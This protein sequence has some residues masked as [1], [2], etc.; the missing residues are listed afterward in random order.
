MKENNDA[1]FISSFCKDNLALPKEFDGKP[2]SDY[3]YWVIH[4]RDKDSCPYGTVSFF[5]LKDGRIILGYSIVNDTST[6]HFDRSLGRGLAFKKVHE[7][8]IHE[9]KHRPIVETNSCEMNDLLPSKVVKFISEYVPRLAKR[10]NLNSVTLY[11]RSDKRE[12]RVFKTE[13][14]NGDYC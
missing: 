10:V 6:D 11:F 3:R 2:V 9:T 13:Y 8:F 14:T 5:S 7:V 12:N 1:K 4:L